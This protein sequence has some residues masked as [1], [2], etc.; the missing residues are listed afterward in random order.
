MHWTQ[1][2][3]NAPTLAAAADATR[4][5]FEAA[6]LFFGHGTDNAWDET[7]WLIAH[8][9]GIQYEAGWQSAL[10]TALDAPADDQI[11]KQL[12]TIAEARIETRKPLAYLLGEAWFAGLKFA[13]NEDVLVPRSPL[14]E[15]ITQGFQ[16]WVPSVDDLSMLDLCTGS[17]CIAIATAL[18]QPTWQVDASDV[19]VAALDVAERNVANYDLGD[20]VTLIEADVFNA[21]LFQQYHLIVSNPPYVDAAEMNERPDEFAREP[22]LG[23]AA[24]DDGLDIVRAI[25]ADAAEHLHDDGVLICEVGASDRALQEEYSTVPFTWL[26]F[27][28]G[29]A[30]VFVLTKSQLRAHNDVLQQKRTGTQ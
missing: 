26:E 21:A 11:V 28:D 3:R 10:Q 2:V 30:G 29:G 19:S 1:Q 14:A 27:D 17:G 20:R 4:H 7:L 25:L 6:G 18:Y 8:L 5:G 16:P 24:G 13:V 22:V 23:L 12:L 9:L 15:L